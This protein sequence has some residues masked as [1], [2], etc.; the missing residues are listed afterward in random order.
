MSA[1]GDALSQHY[2]HFVAVSAIAAF[3]HSVYWI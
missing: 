3:S 1:A 2:G